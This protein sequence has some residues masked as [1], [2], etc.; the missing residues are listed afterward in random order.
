MI[1]LTHQPSPNL[2]ACERTFVPLMSI[3]A[4][5]AR[6]QHQAYCQALTDCG[7][8]VRV[9]DFNLNLPDCAFIEDTAVVLDAVAILCS[10][11]TPSRQAEPAGIEAVLREYR[12]V[13]RIL[14]P[15]TLEGGDVLQIG[16]RLL[17]GQSSRTSGNGIAAFQEITSRFGY[18]VTAIPVRGSLHL[19]TACTAL[20]DGRLLINPDW[21]DVGS[22]AEFDRIPI[23]KEE[24]FAANICLAGQNVLLPGSHR[25]TAELLKQLGFATRAVDISEF[26]KAEGGVTCLSLLFE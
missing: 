10:M 21:V 16:R 6:Q 25:Q 3:D 18:R 2:Q 1:A 4:A 12:A 15:A 24:P 17:V 7:A 20:P 11:G 9:L 26:S 5:L 8:E 13:E 14:P 23:P 22:L 19:K